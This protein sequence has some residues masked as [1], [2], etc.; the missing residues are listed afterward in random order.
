MF[1]VEKLSNDNGMSHTNTHKHTEIKCEKSVKRN[2]HTAE[3]MLL[4]KSI[5][6]ILR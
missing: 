1:V 6:V 2:K 3:H 5:R 4:A